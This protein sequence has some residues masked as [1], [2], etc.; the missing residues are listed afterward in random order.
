MDAARVV[1]RV[2]GEVNCSHLLINVQ[3]QLRQVAV[4]SRRPQVRYACAAHSHGAQ[5]VAQQA[6]LIL[7]M[8]TRALRVCTLHSDVDAEKLAPATKVS[9]ACRFHLL[10]SA[11]TRGCAALH[12]GLWQLCL[13]CVACHDVSQLLLVC[14]FAPLRTRT[15]LISRLKDA[16]AARIF[17][18]SSSLKVRSCVMESTFF[19][20]PRIKRTAA[21]VLVSVAE[22]CCR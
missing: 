2:H 3:P 21:R 1:R 9:L 18:S 11:G 12:P 13:G 8:G 4:L 22:A 15:H 7:G 20:K 10:S 14:W 19:T 17:P 6:H 5:L 16:N